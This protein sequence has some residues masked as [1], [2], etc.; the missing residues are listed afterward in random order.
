MLTRSHKLKDKRPTCNL[1]KHGNVAATGNIDDDGG[2]GKNDDD[3][4]TV[5]YRS[6]ACLCG[7][8]GWSC[9]VL[10]SSSSQ[11]RSPLSL[12]KKRMVCPRVAMDETRNSMGPNSI[13]NVPQLRGKSLLLCEFSRRNSNTRREITLKMNCLRHF[14]A[15]KYFNLSIVKSG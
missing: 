1:C 8:W 7:T 2:G 4:L 5:D 10:C 3:I 6:Y 13:A 15:E 12:L 11:R 14:L 9:T